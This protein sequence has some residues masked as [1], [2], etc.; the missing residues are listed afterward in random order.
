MFDE[1]NI[2]VM[3]CNMQYFLNNWIAVRKDIF[4]LD[5]EIVS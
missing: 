4:Y 5:N 3:S 2:L 1:R